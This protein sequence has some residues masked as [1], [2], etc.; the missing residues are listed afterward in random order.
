MIESFMDEEL[1]V[2]PDVELELADIEPDII[3]QKKIRKLCKKSQNN[4]HYVNNKEFTDSIAKWI[5]ENKNKKDRKYRTDWT[6]M[7]TFVAECILKLIEHYSLKGNWRSYCVDTE[8]E[9]LT[10]RGWLNIDQITENDIIL[11]YDEGD[12]KWSKI[13]SIF[14]DDYDGNMFKLSIQ[15][16]DA[17]VTPRHKFIT[18]NG[19]KEVDYLIK[20]DRLILTG[21]SV[22]DTKSSLIYTNEFVELIGWILT[23]GNIY[24]DKNS[25]RNYKRISISQNEGEFADRIRS[26]L[27]AIGYTYGETHRKQKSKI[28]I[29]FILSK[30]F[31]DKIIEVVPDKILTMNFIL[32]LTQ[33]QRE[34]L[35][36]TMVDGDGWRRRKNN[37]GYCQKDKSHVDTFLALCTISG[38]RVSHKKRDI[39]SYGK[40]TEI[41]DMNFFSKRR[42]VVLV[43]NINFHGANDKKLVGKNKIFNPNEPTVYYNGKVWCPETEY[44]SFMARR[45]GCIYLTGNTYLD[46]MK[47]EALF[48][49][50]KYCHNFN[51][52]KSQNAFA[53]FTT[54]ITNS[55]C[56]ILAKEKYQ[57]N[58]KFKT[59]SEQ[60]VYNYDRIN[61]D[62]ENVDE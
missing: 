37:M 18:D 42:N 59:I 16:M 8:T 35:I 52:E 19:L 47:S 40:P 12:L 13:K 6:P 57:A 21:N 30:E 56:Q 27:N 23:E 9:A 1:D 7:P 53:Y 26:C 50:V 39:I 20:K 38:Y 49:C 58:I 31:Y 34:I 62:C 29:N 2:E 54:Y 48:N 10:Q 60:S 41:Y 33:H 43:D 28:N 24:I 55:F 61:L 45:N 15:G 11:S 32:Q 25:N 22:N 4:P 17:L 51:I 44:G 5:E 46:E 3:P 36:N 14:R